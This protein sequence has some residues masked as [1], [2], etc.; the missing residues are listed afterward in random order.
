[1]A[2][3]SGTITADE[4][5]QWGA[6]TVPTGDD[7]DALTLVIQATEAHVERFYVTN[8]DYSSTVELAI[9]M[10]ASRLWKRRQSIDGVAAV[11]DFGPIRVTRIDSDISM[12][13]EPVWAFG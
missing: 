5:A 6:F 3:V 12:L 2:Y 11:G 9:I 10:Q 4:V 8:D 7:L 13:L 1:L